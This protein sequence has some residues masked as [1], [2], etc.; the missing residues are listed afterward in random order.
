MMISRQSPF[1]K[2]RE[3]A[4]PSEIDRAE[5]ERLVA[6]GARLIEVLPGSV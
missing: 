1:A 4:M 5:V 3:D 2:L 6:G